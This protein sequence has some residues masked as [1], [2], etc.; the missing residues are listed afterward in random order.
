MFVWHV[1]PLGVEWLARVP[2]MLQRP[3]R[4]SVLIGSERLRYAIEVVGRVVDSLSFVEKFVS[5]AR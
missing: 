3:A 1:V 2:I 4:G 5:V